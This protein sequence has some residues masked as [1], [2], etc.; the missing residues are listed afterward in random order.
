M[1]NDFHRL[2]VCDDF[3]ATLLQERNNPHD[4]M[5]KDFVQETELSNTVR[6]TKRTLVS[7]TGTA[8]SQL[9]YIPVLTMNMAN[10]LE[11]K[12]NDFILCNTSSHVHLFMTLK[13]TVSSVE[14][15][16]FVLQSVLC[17]H[18]NKKKKNTHLNVF[19]LCDWFLQM[20]F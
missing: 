3:N 18:G 17:F 12:V 5:F 6:G 15:Y 20:R 2:A 14:N 7:H 4:K 1:Y 13:P 9:D 10:P 19:N 11:T 16:S 8:S